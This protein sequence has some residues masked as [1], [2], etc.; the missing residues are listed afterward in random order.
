MFWEPAVYEHKAK[1]IG[2]PVWEVAN[3][4][5]LLGEALTAE[6]EVYKADFL[7]VGVDVY[8]LEAEACGARLVSNAADQCPEIAEP[9]WSLDDLPRELDLPVLP[10]SGRFPVIL[11]AAQL[12]RDRLKGRL[13][14]LRVAAS[15][16]VS[17]A[18]KLV[19]AQDLLMALASG[20]HEAD[21]ILE[22]ATALACRWCDCLR[23][24]ELEVICFDSSSAPPLI[25]PE[26]YATHI[27]ARHAA[28][29]TNLETAGQNERPLIIGGESTAIVSAMIAAGATSVIC[30]FPTDA[31]AFAQAV[32]AHDVRVRRNVDPGVL[33][34]ADDAI[35]AAAVALSRDLALFEAP[36]AGT[37]VLPYHTDPDKF[38]HLRN[39]AEKHADGRTAG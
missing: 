1:L 12:A 10:E 31:A 5:A 26:M 16:P 23:R 19:G 24:A 22:F 27:Q 34:K 29:L 6:H 4:A 11:E 39:A 30:D 3:S 32:K 14:S 21:V 8:N 18:A 7:T 37:G 33:S 9:L 20:A 2:K 36:V 38:W 17:I 15:G 28:I 13:V 25:G 35:C